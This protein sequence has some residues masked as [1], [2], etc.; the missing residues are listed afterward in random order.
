MHADLENLHIEAT[1]IYELGCLVGDDACGE[2]LRAFE[3]SPTFGYIRFT[4]GQ[5]LLEQLT[6]VRCSKYHST[7]KPR[8]AEKYRLFQIRPQ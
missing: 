5:L 1:D 3:I 8:R 4:G 7:E 2:Y 6:Y